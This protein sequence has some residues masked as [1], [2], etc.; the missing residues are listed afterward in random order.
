[1]AVHKVESSSHEEISIDDPPVASSS[2]FQIAENVDIHM[3]NWLR[4]VFQ[5]YGKG[6][7]YRLF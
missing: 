2:R 1:T 3:K 6:K 7:C 4:K 5:Q